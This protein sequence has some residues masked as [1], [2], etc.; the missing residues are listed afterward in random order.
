MRSVTAVVATLVVAALL[1][2]ADDARAVDDPSLEY[3]TLETAH[4]KLTYPHPLEAVARRVIVLSETIHTRVSSGMQYSPGVKTEMILTD[5]TDSAN[6]SATPIPYNAINLYVTAP[7]DVSAL[8]DYD[9]WYLG[10]VTHE[11]THILHTGN[12]SGAPAIANAIFGRSFAP[13]S[14]QPRWIIEGLAVLF[15]S[16]YSSGGRIRSSLFDT[17]IRVDVLEDNFAR[18][19][20]ISASAQRYP[21]GN[22]FYLYGSRFL[23]WVADVYG[24]DVMPAVSADYGAS[25]VPFGINRAIRRQTGRT[26]EELYDAW[27]THLRRYY[28]DMVKQVD[29]R[30]R[31]E[32][33]RITFH[34]HSVAYPRFVPPSMRSEPGREEIVFYRNDQ[35]DR[36]GIYRF[37]LGDPTVPGAR[38]ETLLIRTNTDAVTSFTPEGGIVFPNQEPWRN[39]WTRHDLFSL[40]PGETATF[41]TEAQRKQLTEGMRANEPDVSPD[42]RFVAFTINSRGT[43]RL[44][45]ATRDHEGNLG[46]PRTLDPGQ[47]LDQAYTPRFSPDGRQIV[48]SAWRAGGFRDIRLVEVASGAASSITSDRALDMQPV[49]SPDGRTIYFSS[50]RTGIFNIYAYDVASKTFQMVT[51]VVGAALMPAISPDGKTLVYTGYTHQGYDLFALPLDPA[52]F[53][54]APVTGQERPAPLPEPRQVPV[55][56]YR[57]NP[58]STFAPRSWFFSLG[59][60]Y[61][62]S[63][64]VTF[65]TS[66]QDIVGH[67]RVSAS[68]TFDPDA[69]EP[70]GAVS[71]TY[72]RLPVDLNF[73]FSRTTLPR[74]GGYQI[75]GRE[76]PYQE[77]R[78]TASTSVDVPIRSAFVDQNVSLS[79][80]ATVFHTRLP[81]PDDLDPESPVTQKPEDGFLSEVR[82]SYGINTSEGGVN[83]AGSK[84]G[85]SLRV[86]ASMA[87]DALGSTQSLYAFD[88]GASAYLTMPWPGEQTLAAR[89]SGAIAAG[90]YARRGIYFVGGY[91]LANASELDLLINGVYSGAFVLRGYPPGAYSGSAFLLGTLE[92]RAPVWIPNW[93][94]STL[95]LF[96]RRLDAAAFIDYGGAFEELDLEDTE[97]FAKG[98]LLHIPGLHTAIGLELWFGLT[99]AHRIDTNFKLGYAYGTSREAAKDGQFYFLASSAF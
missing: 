65:E 13:N 9:D 73:G 63:L 54:D 14:A 22:L 68:A 39:L 38:D 60:G 36:P 20:Q 44:V 57:Y 92:Y 1:F 42:G 11:Y 72:A 70:R 5:N 80:G 41:G 79:Y 49:W 27:H 98:D 34:G 81:I 95:P 2:F 83:A 87:D 43:T 12:V 53:L 18:I 86:G 85:F 3:W 64:A 32:G 28:G 40:P 99:L 6:G 91:D 17:F 45:V 10:L 35:S 59:Q 94:P 71:Y 66:A 26:Y 75:S 21:F 15:E 8:G 90:A 31:R 19:D 4:F 78:S 82:F 96:W 46:E 58:L 67:H 69:P 62:G 48:Y 84:R 88:F 29:A 7:S 52:R 30:G 97:A 47:P 16:D 76:L 51:N 50:D 93:G 89:A 74:L 61:F 77:T 23:R 56:K 33:A 25:L 37:A 55:E 24:D